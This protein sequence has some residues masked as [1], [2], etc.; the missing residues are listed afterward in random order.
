V[1]YCLSFQYDILI[2]KFLDFRC[3]LRDFYEESAPEAIY[4]IP[5]CYFIVRYLKMHHN[6]QVSLNTSDFLR[7][8]LMH[9]D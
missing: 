3:I 1:D 9:S 4:E 7:L 6:A 5:N 2:H 8:L